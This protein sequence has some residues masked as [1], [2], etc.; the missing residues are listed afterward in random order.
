MEV[1]AIPSATAQRMLAAIVFTDAVDFSARIGDDEEGTVNLIRQDLDLMRSLCSD[2]EGQVIK[3]RGDGLMMLFTSAVQAVS[4]AIEIQKHFG[5][6]LRNEAKQDVLT[7]R[8]GIHLGDVLVTEDDALGDGVNV[9][10]RLEEEA[11]PGGI[12]MSK[13]VYD[14]VRNR[15]F[16]EA[17]KLGDLKLRNISEPVAAYKIAGVGRARRH[18]YARPH[19]AVITAIG[20][21]LVVFGAAGSA[22]YVNYHSQT[23]ENLPVQSEDGLVLPN[24][25]IPPIFFTKGSKSNAEF[26]DNLKQY[27]KHWEDFGRSFADANGRTR[28]ET[29]KKLA[30]SA[31]RAKGAISTLPRPPEPPRAPSAGG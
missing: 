13:T 9:A 31:R 6:R 8:I 21:L 14:V 24:L 12:C 7:H 10:A 17:T 28:A 20:I 1:G 29:G 27:E 30:E 26:R 16:L 5:E 18:H 11:E 22:L 25:S 3:S 19:W 23:K 4:C 15:L 2:F